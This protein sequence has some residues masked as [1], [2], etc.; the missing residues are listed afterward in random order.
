MILRVTLP[1]LMSVSLAAAQDLD[2][3]VSDGQ[4]AQLE[5]SL[6]AERDTDALRMLALAHAN[7][8][9]TQIED[10]DTEFARVQQRFDRWIEAI[11]RDDE[12]HPI[13]QA[14]QLAT[15]FAGGA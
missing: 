4:L 10:R 2:T 5:A 13:Q 3:L 7:K 1:L 8:A 12:Q 11:E 14:V 15:A 9:R 6:P